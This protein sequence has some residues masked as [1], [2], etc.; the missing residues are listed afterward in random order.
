MAN[1]VR[2]FVEEVLPALI[3]RRAAARKSAKPAPKAEVERAAAWMTPQPRE[4]YRPV[5]DHH[6]RQSHLR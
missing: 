1:I 4:P 6:L 2:A 3:A 5:S